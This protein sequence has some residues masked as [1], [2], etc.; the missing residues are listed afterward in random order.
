MLTPIQI[1]APLTRSLTL[2]LGSEKAITQIPTIKMAPKAAVRPRS[3]NRSRTYSITMMSHRIGKIIWWEG[4]MEPKLL[5]SNPTTLL[6]IKIT[7]LLILTFSQK[8]QQTFLMR[9]RCRN[10]RSSFRHVLVKSGLISKRNKTI[11][12]KITRVNLKILLKK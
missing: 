10:L 8:L 11:F 9:K 5:S 4:K 12:K 2:I 6:T 1:I 7:A 3:I